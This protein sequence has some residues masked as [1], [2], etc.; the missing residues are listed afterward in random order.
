[1]KTL[2]ELL[3]EIGWSPRYFSEYLGVNDRTVRRW[4]TDPL[5]PI[6]DNVYAWLDMLAEVRRVCPFPEG[7]MHTRE[8]LTMTMVVRPTFRD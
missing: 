2:P 5:Y 8:P 4:S 1:M 3:R 6:P 7:W